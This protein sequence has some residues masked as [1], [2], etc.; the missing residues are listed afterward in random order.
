[1]KMTQQVGHRERLLAI[2]AFPFCGAL[3]ILSGLYLYLAPQLPDV[4]SLKAVKFE[5]PL[6]VLSRDGRL[7]AEFGEKHTTPLTYER[8]VASV[9]HNVRRAVEIGAEG[10]VVHT[11]SYVATTGERGLHDAALKRVREGLL[12]LLERL[13]DDAMPWLLLEPTAG[14]G[15]SLCA[16]VE[17]LAAYSSEESIRKFM[18]GNLAKLVSVP[19][20][21]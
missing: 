19:V 1:M 14:Q 16:G 4:E 20:P 13:E 7:I 9:A 8:S 6:Q 2:L 11:G 18:G 21:A 5:T 12:P 17:D 3:L 15:R 10:L